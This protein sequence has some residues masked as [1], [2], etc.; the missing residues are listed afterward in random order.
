MRGYKNMIYNKYNNDYK[1]ILLKLDMPC[2]EYLKKQANIHDISET[3]LI[4]KILKAYIKNCKDKIK[5]L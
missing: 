3:L 2:H 1:K 4:N 5:S